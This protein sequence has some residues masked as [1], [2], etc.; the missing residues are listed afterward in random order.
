MLTVTISFPYRGETHVE[1]IH[2]LDAKTAVTILLGATN[3]I[4]EDSYTGEVYAT[5]GS[6]SN[7]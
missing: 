3:A 1:T 6:F 2:E 4:I 5:K 7:K